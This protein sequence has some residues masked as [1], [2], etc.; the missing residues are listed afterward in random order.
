MVKRAKGLK[1][2][3]VKVQELLSDAYNGRIVLPDFQRSFIWEPEDV[4]QLLISVLGDYFICT[5]LLL[6]SLR[7]ESIFA[8]RLRGC[9]RS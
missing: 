9:K 1:G 6:D 3:V 8:L 4:R 2:I 7:D 5:M